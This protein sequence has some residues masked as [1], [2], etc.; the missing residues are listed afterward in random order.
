[1]GHQQ[2]PCQVKNS[3]LNR[4]IIE[5]IPRNHSLA[6]D[7]TSRKVAPQPV[8]R[9]GGD[10]NQRVWAIEVRGMIDLGYSRRLRSW[11]DPQILSISYHKV[12]VLP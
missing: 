11:S 10:Q 6:N 7:L 2:A 9:S 4:S 8:G 3:A 5:P 1:M 12:L